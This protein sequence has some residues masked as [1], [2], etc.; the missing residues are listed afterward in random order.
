MHLV[1]SLQQLCLSFRGTHALWLVVAAQQSYSVPVGYILV[2]VGSN[3]VVAADMAVAVDTVAVDMGVVVVEGMA[4]VGD[5]VAV[6]DMVVVVDI[7]VGMLVGED[8]HKVV[9]FHHIPA[10]LHFVVVGNT[11][12][13][14]V[15]QSSSLV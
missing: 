13:L 4:A 9:V 5:I 7:V 8:L 11:D 10:L 6:G 12:Y 1:H 14:V 2:A 3:Q 15:V